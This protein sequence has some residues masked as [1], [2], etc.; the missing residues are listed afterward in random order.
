MS[1]DGII[2]VRLPQALLTT[3][4]NWAASQNLSIHRAAIDLIYWMPDLD[5]NELLSLREPPKESDNPRV[6]LHVGLD[7]IHFL[8]EVTSNSG[9]G[10]SS[11][12]RRFLHAYLVDRTVEVVQRGQSWVLQPI[13]QEPRKK[14]DGNECGHAAS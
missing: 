11:A 14:T 4:R 13:S 8:A 5:A 1:G 2:S 9:L 12:F 6:S 3:F 7:S 10:T